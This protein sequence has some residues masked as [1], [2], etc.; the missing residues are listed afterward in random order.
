MRLV[1]ARRRP[2]FVVVRRMYVVDVPINIAPT[3]FTIYSIELEIA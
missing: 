2:S 1:Q 3:Y